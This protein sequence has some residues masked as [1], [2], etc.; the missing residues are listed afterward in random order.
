MHAVLLQH[1]HDARL[2]ANEWTS[3]DVE[4][5]H[6]TKVS[7][8][9]RDPDDLLIYHYSMGWNFGLHL[10]RDLNCRTAIK[11]HNI[12]PPEFFAG[13]SADYENAC[14]LGREQIK[15][16]VQANCD[17]YLADSEYNSWELLQEGVYKSK[18]F[19]VPPFHLIDK[20]EVLAPDPQVLENYVD[21]KINILMVGRVAPNKGHA[22]LIDALAVYRREY[23]EHARLLI[24]GKEVEPLA[25]YSQWLRQMIA[26]LDLNGSVVFAGCVSDEQL[27]S[28]YLAADFFM[29]TSEHEGFCVP[30]VEAMALKVPIIACASSAIPSTVGKAGIVWNERNPYLL[31]ES[32]NY[33]NNDE[34]ISAALALMGRRRYEEFF[35]NERIAEEFFS[36][37]NTASLI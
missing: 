11:Y 10:L 9:L 29:L 2:F 13:I 12:T 3:K 21:D 23:N 37:L 24:V 25:T 18:C 1:G 28:Y 17:L 36:A 34:S 7:N 6:A 27:K 33:L 15:D 19:V 5:L 8:F 22:A 14:E 32:V 31:A 16:I 20:L 4:V 30:L 35:S 26:R